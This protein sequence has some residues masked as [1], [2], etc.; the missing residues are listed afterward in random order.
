MMEDPLDKGKTRTTEQSPAHR[1]EKNHAEQ[2]LQRTPWPGS[3]EGFLV[4]IG[5]NLLEKFPY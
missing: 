2:E 1:R 5:S 3:K 4:H